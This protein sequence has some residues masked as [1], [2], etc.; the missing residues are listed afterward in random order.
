MQ[1][2]LLLTQ[3]DQNSFTQKNQTYFKGHSARFIFRLMSTNPVKVQSALKQLETRNVLQISLPSHS[4][5]SLLLGSYRLFCTGKAIFIES[6]VK[7]Y[8]LYKA[9]Q[10][11]HGT[12]Q[13]K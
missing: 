5:S 6:Q 4:L 7:C 13:Q 11:R 3:V 1:N 12:I 2:K 8:L 10:S 9:F